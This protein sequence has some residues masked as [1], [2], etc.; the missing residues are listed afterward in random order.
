MSVKRKDSGSVL[1]TNCYNGM[2]GNAGCGVQGP[3]ATFG[4]VFNNNGGGVYAV[5]LRDAGIRT[6]FFPRNNIPS[7]IVTS[8]SEFDF[9]GED[10]PS[11]ERQTRQRRAKR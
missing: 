4:E 1:T 2:A 5:E 9:R 6:W 3:P 8:T 7:D 11:E 10:H